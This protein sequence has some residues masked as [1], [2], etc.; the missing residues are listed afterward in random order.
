MKS[1]EK[2]IAEVI[3]CNMDKRTKKALRAAATPEDVY[4][5]MAEAVEDMGFTTLGKG[6]QAHFLVWEIMQHVDENLNWHHVALRVLHAVTKK[7]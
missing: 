2:L 1:L 6:P 5:I 4:A 3:I 7:G